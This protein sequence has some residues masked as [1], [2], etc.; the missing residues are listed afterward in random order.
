[1]AR[2]FDS[3]DVARH[4]GPLIFTENVDCPQ[5][6]TLFVAEFH[7]HSMSVEDIAEAPTGEHTCPACGHTWISEVTGWTFYSEAG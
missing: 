4:G 5:C 7:D 1:M 3:D 6:D 2:A